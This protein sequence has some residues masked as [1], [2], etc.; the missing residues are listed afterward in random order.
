M[1]ILSLYWGMS[2]HNHVNWYTRFGYSVFNRIFYQRCL[3]IFIS[4]K[5]FFYPI[6]FFCYTITI[7]FFFKESKMHFC[8]NSL[9]QLLCSFESLQRSLT[10]NSMHHDPK[11]HVLFVVVWRIKLD[12]KNIKYH[13]NITLSRYLNW[14]CKIFSKT[15]IL[16]VL[17]VVT[18]FFNKT[19]LYNNLK[20]LFG[21]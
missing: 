13:C 20:C 6:Q 11:R 14:S 16:Q 12:Y 15:F 10:L 17:L 3:Q 9:Q 5:R 4:L 18:I 21:K 8:L 2:I 19:E 1:L 7:E